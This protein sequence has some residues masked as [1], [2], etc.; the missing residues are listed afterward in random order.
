M[1]I[2]PT[3]NS[4]G[5]AA[6]GLT[7]MRD[8]MADRSDAVI[9]ISGAWW[10]VNKVKAGVPNEL[11]TMLKLESLALSSLAL[12]GLSKAISKKILPL[13]SVCKTGYL[14]RR[15]RL[16]P[17]VRRLSQFVGLIVDQLKNLRLLA[18]MYRKIKTPHSGARRGKAATTLTAHVRQSGTTC[19]G[20]WWE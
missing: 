1:E 6:D 12:A 16:L 13:L 18:A 2:V 4:D 7:P 15:M 14:T 19:K 20:R 3:D 8:W 11:D 10:D 17:T 9:C 5:P